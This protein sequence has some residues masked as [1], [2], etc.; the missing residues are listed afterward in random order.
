MKGIVTLQE[1]KLVKPTESCGNRSISINESNPETKQ[2][3]RRAIPCECKTFEY[4]N[5][6]TLLYTTDL[7]LI[8]SAAIRALLKKVLSCILASY[9]KQGIKLCFNSVNRLLWPQPLKTEQNEP[10]FVNLVST[11]AQ[12]FSAMVFF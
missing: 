7:I 2:F 11:S 1:L 5:K 8:S 4:R 12:V 10:N 9:Q 6:T 3:K